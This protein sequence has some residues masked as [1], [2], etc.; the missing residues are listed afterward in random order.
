MPGFACGRYAQR[1]SKGGSSDA[2]LAILQPLVQQLVVI[3]SIINIVY[4]V[5]ELESGIVVV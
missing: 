3:N 2:S 4:R 5:V 1:Y